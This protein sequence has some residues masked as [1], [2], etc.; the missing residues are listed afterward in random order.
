MEES[1][2]PENAGELPPEIVSVMEQW[3][4]NQLHDFPTM[5][6]NAASHA[7]VIANPKLRGSVFDYE[8]LLTHS[9]RSILAFCIDS[10]R[11]RS[12]GER[13]FD[14]FCDGMSVE[15][16]GRVRA[17]EQ[18]EE[19]EDIENLPVQ[20]LLNATRRTVRGITSRRKEERRPP[21]LPL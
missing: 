6:E 4:N 8:T 12:D 10:S 16:V 3:S 5:V 11:S 14:H 19:I 15:L 21:I 17:T 7:C 1:H 20:K 13:V 2:T 9:L 18:Y